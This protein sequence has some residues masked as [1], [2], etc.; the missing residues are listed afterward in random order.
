MIAEEAAAGGHETLQRLEESVHTH[1]QLFDLDRDQRLSR[2]D[3]TT[4]VTAW[5]ITTDAADNFRRLDLDGDGYLQQCEIVE[6]LRQFYFSND[7][8]A[9]GNL[10]YGYF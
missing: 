6:Y 3:Y 8:E 10:F 4:W 1:C 7:P 9:P 2:Q 5:G